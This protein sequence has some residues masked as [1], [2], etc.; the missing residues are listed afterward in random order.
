[1]RT[2]HAYLVR[3]LLLAPCLVLLS[4]LRLEY[5]VDRMKKP[6]TPEFLF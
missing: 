4:W 6:I 3:L 5:F 1:M 2:I